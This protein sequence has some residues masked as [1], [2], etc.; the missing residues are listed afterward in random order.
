MSKKELVKTS[1]VVENGTLLEAWLCDVNQYGDIQSNGSQE[2]L[3][4]YNGKEYIVWMNMD[5]EPINP[6]EMILS[7]EF[8]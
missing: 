6:D 1:T 3:Y 2:F 4:S 5:D 7:I 8:K